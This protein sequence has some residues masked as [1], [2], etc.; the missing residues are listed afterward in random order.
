MSVE[1][2]QNNQVLD[3]NGGGCCGGAQVNDPFNV[4]IDESL[5]KCNKFYNTRPL[6]SKLLR[7]YTLMY[8]CVKLFAWTLLIKE[9]LDNSQ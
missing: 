7:C 8:T 6:R 1:M 5:S 2:G 4:A 9:T 3:F